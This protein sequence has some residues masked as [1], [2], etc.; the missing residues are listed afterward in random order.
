M[1]Q[2]GILPRDR[3]IPDGKIM[4]HGKIMPR[5]RILQTRASAWVNGFVWQF[6]VLC[7]G[8]GLGAWGLGVRGAVEPQPE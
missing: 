4:P 3:I 7:K 8:L 1:P 2:D 6:L 5:D